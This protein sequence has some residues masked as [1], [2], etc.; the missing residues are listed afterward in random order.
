[1]CALS[2][3]YLYDKTYTYMSASFRIKII[4]TKS[5]NCFLIHVFQVSLNNLCQK[6]KKTKS[7]VQLKQF[8]KKNCRKSIYKLSKYIISICRIT[9]SKPQM[10]PKSKPG[11]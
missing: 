7:S 4:K 11:V 3:V 5:E 6:E 8:L 10:N 2:C 9:Q 1:M